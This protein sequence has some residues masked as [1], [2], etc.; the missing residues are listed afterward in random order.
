[1]RWI[2]SLVSIFSIALAC[3]GA[4]ASED[5]PDPDFR[6]RFYERKLEDH[7]DL[8]AGHAALGTAY[9]D[10]ARQSHD[11]VWIGKARTALERSLKLQP[12]LNALVAMAALCSFSHRFECALEY[13]ARA[14]SARADDTRIRSIRMEAYLGLGR[15]DAAK[16]LLESS[17]PA[18]DDPLLYAARG[19]WLAE[20]GR[21]DEARRAFA[22]AAERGRN[23]GAT[24]L[25]I[26]SD[27]NAAGMLLDSGRAE[28]ALAHLEAAS[29]LEASSPPVATAL[30]IHW[31]EYQHAR[32]E[33]EQ[34]LSIYEEI[35]DEAEDPEIARRAFVLAQE[36]G[37]D[38]QAQSLFERAER[39]AESV[40]AAS[41]I[42]SLETHAR[43]YADARVKLERAEQLAERNLEWKRDRAARE[44]LEYVRD[45]LAATR[46]Q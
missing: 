23:L 33:R 14:A 15:T 42:Y 11:V 19:R 3:A 44:T 18:D 6:I 32:G 36:L 24:D 25:A 5:P 4:F 27:T 28:P 1:M 31:A 16:A 35:L 20:L 30:R 40:L 37:R 7:P 13:A 17:S 12:N 38:E 21:Y 45:R 26:W 43:L 39:A 46:P 8:F 34:A 10:K 41:E 22:D 29:E 2:S 9:L